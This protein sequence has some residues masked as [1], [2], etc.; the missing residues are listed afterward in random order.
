MPITKDQLE[1]HIANLERQFNEWTQRKAQADSQVQAL[2]GALQL[3][4]QLHQHEVHGIPMPPPLGV[5]G[6]PIA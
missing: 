6:P 2:G 5:T 4:R 3:A 1:A